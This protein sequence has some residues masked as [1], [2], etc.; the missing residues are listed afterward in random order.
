MSAVDL[1]ALPQVRALWPS[2]ADVAVTRGTTRNRAQYFVFP[3]PTRPRLLVPAGVPGARR[4]F[5]R[6]GGGLAERAARE[7]WRLAHRTGVAAVVPM[8][9]L[10]V[11]PD[12]DGIEACLEHVVGGKVRIGVLLGP[13]RA[14]LKPVIQVFDA[15]GETVAFAKLGVNPLTERLV[16]R[17]ADAL[18]LVAKRQPVSFNAPELLYDG[19]WRSAAINVQRALP[20][21]QSS[22]APVEPPYAVMA[23][24]AELDGEGVDDL[25]SS[26]FLSSLGGPQ[27]DAWNGIDVADL[28][29]LRAAVASHGACPMGSWHGDLGP[30]NMATDGSVVNVWDWERFDSRVPYGLDA[31][32]YRT[33]VEVGRSEPADAWPR[34]LAD[35]TRLLQTGQ[36]PTDAAPVI[37]AAYLLTITDRYMRDVAGDPTAAMRRRMSWLA[38]AAAAALNSLEARSR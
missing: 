32:H 29:R 8:R 24:I 11:R 26:P 13:P 12:P 38:G 22:L 23:E 16:S 36:R 21:A 30:W 6:H 2:P 33:Q 1:A 20:L 34:V 19:S 15:M 7:A 3:S 31:A 18:R 28:R 14:N 27:D 4:M 37:G 9:R 10:S 35:V 25:G 5:A 17:E